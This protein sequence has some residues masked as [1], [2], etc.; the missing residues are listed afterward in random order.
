MGGTVSGVF[1]VA[2]EEGDQLR[3]FPVAGIG[4]YLVHPV[5][6]LVEAFPGLEDGLRAA[7]YLEANRTLGDVS[8]HGAGMAVRLVRLARRVVY[9]DDGG[10]QVAAI[11][12]RQSMREIGGMARSCSGL[13]GRKAH[14]ERSDDSNSS[15]IKE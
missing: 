13:R 8:D 14:A 2:D 1:M 11:Q 7:L 12:L 5:R 3:R 9:F 4:R 15:V 6:R 10:A